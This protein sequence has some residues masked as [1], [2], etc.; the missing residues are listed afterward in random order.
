[1]NAKTEL[2]QKLCMNYQYHHNYP[3]EIISII[4]NDIGLQC[5][6]VADIGAGTGNLSRLLIY[7]G[8]NVYAVEQNTMLREVLLHNLSFYRSFNAISSPYEKINLDDNSVDL[9]TAG[10]AL[11]LFD[12]SSAKLECQR[13][14]KKNACAL[15]VFNTVYTKSK[16]YKDYMQGLME[17]G[18]E[19]E[20]FELL[21]KH[22]DEPN[23][24]HE[25]QA[26]RF[27][28]NSF[29]RREIIR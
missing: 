27:L 22:Y 24:I 8:F 9:I 25:N 21:K 13:I 3:H 4:N 18:K 6:T 14:I 5:G 20:Q 10:Q 11:Q 15:L 29:N 19:P 1:M 28:G 16:Y 26:T 2:F 17:Y 12:I 23:Y 7:A